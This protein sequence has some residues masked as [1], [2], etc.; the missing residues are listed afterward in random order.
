MLTQAINWM[1]MGATVVEA[2][3]L[4]RVA[5]LKL[6]RIYLFITLFCALNVL[7]DGVMW[8]VGWDS[9]E[10]ANVFIYSLFFYTV[11]FPFAAWDALEESKAQMAKVR[12]LQT[13]RMVSGLFLTGICALIVVFSLDPEDIH[14]NSARAVYMGLFLLTGAASGAAAFLWFLYRYAR[15]QKIVLAHNTS[16]WT[17]FF[18]LIAVLQILDCLADMTRGLIP[19]KAADIGAMVLLALNVVLLGWCIFAL[20]P[21]PRDVQQA[22][23]KASP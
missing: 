17:M 6:Y 16:V 21:V 1:Q 10:A 2:L 18:M 13:L 7:F 14:G 9:R 22:A 3:L 12:R 11:L 4:L 20:K 5:G 23:E 8:Y 19:D 15:A